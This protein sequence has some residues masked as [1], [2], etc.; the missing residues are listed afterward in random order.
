MWKKVPNWEE[1]EINELGEVRNALT[2]NIIIGD[3]NNAGYQRV[4]FYRN[5]HS[6]KFFRHRL[7][8]ELFLSNP[9]HYEEVNH[10]DGNKNNN[11]VTNLEWCNRTHN[12]REARRTG[13]K[14]YK[15][16]FVEFINGSKCRYE[17][18]IELA[19]EI[20]VTKRTVQNYLQGKS[21]GY[22]DKG[23]ISIQYL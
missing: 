10:K 4:C 19:N 16:F 14:E 21:K 5:K 13:I 9:K 3:I 7:V 20:G 17:F 11:S 18:A 12:E 1:Y 8:A 15:P 23:I 22:F 2:G 6:Q